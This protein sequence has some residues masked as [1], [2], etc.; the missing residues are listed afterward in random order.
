MEEQSLT[1][2]NVGE[3]AE[4]IPEKNRKCEQRT[5][6]SKGVR[7]L[8]RI[9]IV[10]AVLV[11]SVIL[12]F[13]LLY[14]AIGSAWSSIANYQANEQKKAAVLSSIFEENRSENSAA[15][16]KRIHTNYPSVHEFLVTD[17]IE[18]R[19][20]GVD[21]KGSTT[22]NRIHLFEFYRNKEVGFPINFNL[23]NADFKDIS[24]W[25]QSECKGEKLEVEKDSG[26]LGVEGR[27]PILVCITTS[28]G[29]TPMYIRDNSIRN[30]TRASFIKLSNEP[31]KTPSSLK[32][33]GES[34]TEPIMYPEGKSPLVFTY[35][36]HEIYEELD[37][38][39]DIELM[40]TYHLIY[41]NVTVSADYSSEYLSLGT[42]FLC[43]LNAKNFSC[44]KEISSSF[45]GPKN[46]KLPE[47]VVEARRGVKVVGDIKPTTYHFVRI[48][49]SSNKSPGQIVN[50][51]W[52]ENETV[53]VS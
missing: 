8:S 34:F 29:E 21:E 43:D 15:G 53:R 33:I 25:T 7:I 40:N 39:K 38:R 30:S 26:E 42:T 12:F 24:S 49:K 36:K 19:Y 1:Q 45:D 11:G 22:Y 37:D 27:K 14:I 10:F 47:G 3:V 20:L 23:Y 28:S 51:P 52:E 41:F 48:Y 2:N 18:G 13:V 35:T 17:D 16:N 32:N 46:F 5:Q 44:Q 50:N 4:I 31:T 6:R 9:L